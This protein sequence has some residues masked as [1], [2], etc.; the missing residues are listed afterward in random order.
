MDSFSVVV[1]SLSLI[2]LLAF[3]I[4]LIKRALKLEKFRR[5]IAYSIG[6]SA[7]LCVCGTII[8]SYWSPIWKY[9][10]FTGLV[11][12]TFGYALLLYEE[13]KEGLKEAQ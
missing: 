4:G 1:Y 12:F 6:F 9:V 5:I 11:V 2:L 10:A 13:F 7:I 3:I 8:R